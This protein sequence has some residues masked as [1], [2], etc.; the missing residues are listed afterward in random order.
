MKLWSLHDGKRL[1]EVALRT[2]DDVR[3][4]AGQRLMSAADYHRAMGRGTDHHDK[5][6]ELWGVVQFNY[7]K[8]RIVRVDVCQSE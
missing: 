1:R 6:M 5:M 8:A 2:R 4:W 3:H 7:P